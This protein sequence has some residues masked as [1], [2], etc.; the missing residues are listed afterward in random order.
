MAT[1]ADNNFAPPKSHV[2]DVND[3]N[4]HVLATRGQRF[5]LWADRCMFHI[6]QVQALRTRLSGGHHRR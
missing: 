6:R 5:P 4:G 1:P 2:A 3:Q